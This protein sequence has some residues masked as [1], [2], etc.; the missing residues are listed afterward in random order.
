MTR[1]EY[2]KE[3]SKVATIFYMDYD[4]NPQKKEIM[5]NDEVSRI[6]CNIINGALCNVDYGDDANT[7]ANA[8]EFIAI[9]FLTPTGFSISTYETIHLPIIEWAKMKEASK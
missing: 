9:N 5:A 2:A 1:E 3:K 4:G 6:I 8:A 7:T